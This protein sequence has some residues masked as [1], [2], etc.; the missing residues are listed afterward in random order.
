MKSTSDGFALNQRMPAAIE[1]G[2]DAPCMVAGIHKQVEPRVPSSHNGDNIANH[3]A[4]RR[5][6]DAD[7]LREGRQ[8]TFAVRVEE[9]F[10]KQARLELFKRKLKRPGSA[11]LHRLGDELQLASAL[12]DG[13]ASTNQRGE[14]VG[15]PEP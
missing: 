12:I 4:G 8:L 9:S 15:G 5:S 14:T 10:S 7:A 11:R 13:N 2:L 3:R 1:P 6:D